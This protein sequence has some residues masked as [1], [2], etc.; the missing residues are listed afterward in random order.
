VKVKLAGR[1]VKTPCPE[2]LLLVLSIHAAKHVWGRLIWLCDIA[3]IVKRERID[4]ESVQG[5]ARELGVQRILNITFL[6]LQRFLGAAI[7]NAMK[8]VVLADRAAQELAERIAPAVASGVSY[9]EQQGS[10]FR[11]MMRLRERRVDRWRF[12]ARLTF[13]PGPGEWELVRLP[14]VLF[15][16]YLLVRLGRLA[17]RLSRG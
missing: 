8:N 6:L 12:L 7:P 1:Q 4:W 14:R 10:Y 5:S 2:D 13:T 15:P 3:E 11:L 16:F 9:G 17:A